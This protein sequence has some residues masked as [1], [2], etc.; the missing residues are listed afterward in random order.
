MAAGLLEVV[1]CNVRTLV[2]DGFRSMAGPDTWFGAVLTAMLTIYIALIGYQ[3]ILGRGGL[4]VTDLPVSVI[5]T[6][7]IVAF[8]TSWA[9]YQSVVYGLLFDGPGQVVA[10]LLSALPAQTAGVSGDVIGSVEQV[11]DRLS[12]AASQYGAMASPSAN[13][14]QGGPMLGAGLLW[15]SAI[16][17]LMLTIGLLLAAKIVLAFLLALGPLFI[18]FMLF[19]ATR[20]IFEGWF[21]ASISFA[22]VPIAVTV[23]GAV[24]L[25]VLE[26]YVAEVYD[27]AQRRLFDMSPVILISLIISVFFLVMAFALSALTRIGGGFALPPRAPSPS[28]DTA[29]RRAATG[30]RSA[31]SRFGSAPAGAAIDAAPDTARWTFRETALA[32]PSEV[33]SHLTAPPPLS[34]RLGQAYPRTGRLGPSGSGQ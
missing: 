4:R 29:Q 14:L 19:D 15:L 16:V 31:F 18:G 7:V 9:A 13:L 27:N 34:E 11:F 22:L 17:I 24:M 33:A 2:H 32:R 25:I 26:P 12:A 10:S 23:L 5:K 6:G 21:R 30:R 1:D 28:S 3:L 20:G 8:M